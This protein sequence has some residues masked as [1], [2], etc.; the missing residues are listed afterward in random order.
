[1]FRIHTC[2]G[3]EQGKPHVI[4]KWFMNDIN[5]LLHGLDLSEW[6]FCYF[7]HECTRNVI[8]YIENIF[9]KPNYIL[10]FG[11]SN[12]LQIVPFPLNCGWWKWFSKI[13]ITSPAD[14]C[15]VFTILF[16]IFFFR[17]YI[18]RFSKTHMN[19]LEWERT[20]VQCLVFCCICI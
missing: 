19:E 10:V 2:N 14:M 11:T 8:K 5:S 20:F 13:Q 3:K 18:F 9:A 15:R 16:F 7:E 17:F 12:K 1:M 4:Y 6:A